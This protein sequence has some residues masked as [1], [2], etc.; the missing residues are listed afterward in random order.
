[1]ASVAKECCIWAGQQYVALRRLGTPD[2][3]WPEQHAQPASP[4]TTSSAVPRAKAAPKSTAAAAVTFQGSMASAAQRGAAATHRMNGHSLRATSVLKE[5]EFEGVLIFCASCGRCAWRTPRSLKTRCDHISSP[6]RAA[7]LRRLERGLFPWPLPGQQLRTSGIRMIAEEQLQLLLRH[8]GPEKKGTTCP[9]QGTRSTALG[10]AVVAWSSG[11]IHEQGAAVELLRAQR[12]EV[13]TAC[14]RPQTQQHRVLPPSIV[15]FRVFGVSD[16]RASH[17][18]RLGTS[19]LVCPHVR[20][21]SRYQSVLMCFSSASVFSGSD[22]CTAS[23]PKQ[24]QRRLPVARGI[25]KSRTVGC[26]HKF[27]YTRCSFV[28]EHSS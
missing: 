23:P 15:R 21:G 18:H 27:V 13:A 2:V 11:R 7:Q 1:L 25:L 9:A 26:L 20:I 17:F 24:W 14:C 19:N 28:H 5:S 12:R 16:G 10:T 22:G 6:S 3:K 4:A 8:L